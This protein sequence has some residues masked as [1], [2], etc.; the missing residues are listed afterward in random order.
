MYNALFSDSP[1]RR[2]VAMRMR[3][4]RA[5][6]RRMGSPQPLEA[7]TSLSQIVCA[8]L[9]EI[10]W[11]TIARASVVNGSPRRTMWMPGWSATSRAMTASRSVSERVASSQ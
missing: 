4:T 2:N 10:C 11:P 8:A 6:S 7:T 1:T 5:G 9:T 3:P